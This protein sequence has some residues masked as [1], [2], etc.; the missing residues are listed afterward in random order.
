MLSAKSK[1]KRKELK[2]A[3]N[4]YLSTWQVV[5]ELLTVLITLRTAKLKVQKSISLC[6]VLRSAFEQLTHRKDKHHKASMFLSDQV[7]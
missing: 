3:E 5:R 2:N 1:S 4:F 6:S 7:S